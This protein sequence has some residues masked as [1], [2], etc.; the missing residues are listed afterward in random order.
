L[1]CIPDLKMVRPIVPSNSENSSQVVA[2]AFRNR[3]GSPVGVFRAPGR[4]NLIGEHTDYND[5]FVMP[6]ALGFSTYVAVGVCADRTLNIVSLDLD[7]TA[8]I[9]LDDLGSG[10]SGHWN[11]YV[12]GVAAMIQESGVVLGGANLVIKSDVP[13]GAGL[14][15]SA[16]IEVSVA[17]ALLA[18]AGRQLD[19]RE[20][21]ALCQRAE[22]QF[23]GTKCGIMDQYISCFGRAGH[24]LLLDC[25][26][27]SHE[28]L[29]V[30]GDV[31]I[32]VCNTMV[33]HELAGGEYN[34]RRAD[35][36]D[37]V[38]ILQANLPEV[39]ALRDIDMSQLGL[40]D[41]EMPERV[42]RR[43]RHVVTENAR[44]LEAAQA[45]RRHDLDSFG[46]LMG[47][48]HRSLRDDY[49]VSCE[50][51]DLM[52]ELGRKCDGVFGA[53]MTGGGFGGCT[54]NLVQAE[55]V[56]AFKAAVSRQYESATGYSPAIYVC[57]A[58][59]GAGPV[60]TEIG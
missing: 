4:V 6:A 21:A 52:V 2:N 42:Y 8:T 37:G 3:Y 43:C 34:Q 25:R 14:S 5:G 10:P 9:S 54:V 1:H 50:E 28:L 35:C 12:R 18:I 39:R 13:I 24:A 47:E 58:A 33:K 53:R 45:L 31:R 59:D 55:A 38:R 30:P 27:R 23:A 60:V 56:D 57:T 26:T 17:F 11:D 44:V 51:L 15:S 20:V 22:H 7:E 32:V 41:A 16:A 40:F 46:R 48:S 36:D 49:E 19:R 29:E